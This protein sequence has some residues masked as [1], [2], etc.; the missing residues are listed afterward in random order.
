MSF[1]NPE[2]WWLAVRSGVL[3]MAFIAFAWALLASRRDTTLNFLRLSS[4]HDQALTEIHRL[5]EKL[6]E[7]S[8]QVHELSLPFPMVSRSAPVAEAIQPVSVSP[9]GA[10]GY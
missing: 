4:Q 3:F 1:E 7:L 2:T 8:A 10:R 5:A 6:G 9:S